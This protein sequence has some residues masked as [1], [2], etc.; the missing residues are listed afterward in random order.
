MMEEASQVNSGREPA[1]IKSLRQKQARSSQGRHRQ[2]F[3]VDVASLWLKGSAR[4]MSV[5]ELSKR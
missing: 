5:L 4:F 2:R 3:F 1:R